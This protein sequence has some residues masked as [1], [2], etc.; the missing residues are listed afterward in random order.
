MLCV[1]IHIWMVTLI[2]WKYVHAL[3]RERKFNNC[4]KI[5]PFV[6][7][8]A[9]SDCVSMSTH[10]H[11]VCARF[12]WSNYKFILSVCLPVCLSPQYYIYL[13]MYVWSDPHSIKWHITLMVFSNC[14][15]N[16]EITQLCSEKW[17]C[18]SC[19]TVLAGMNCVRK[20]KKTCMK[21]T[22]TYIR[23]T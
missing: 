18:K 8:P 14:F 21:D 2:V 11:Y 4:S 5:F 17:E 23:K 22:Y 7:V 6:P 3:K 19:K 12:H 9:V 15:A 1:H 16:C 10:V 20:R 13:C